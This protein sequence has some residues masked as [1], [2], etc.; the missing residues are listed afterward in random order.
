MLRTILFTFF[1]G[2]VL[3]TADYFSVGAYIH[4]EKWT[5]LAFFFVVSLLQHRLME[6]GFKENRERFVQFYLTTV[7][8]RLLM[9]LVFVG[10]FL[11]FKVTSPNSFVVTFFAFYLF[12]TCFEIYGLYRNL[13]RDLE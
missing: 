2:I 4:P 7:V 3:F 10:V 1:L 11:Y 9:C 5:I 12:Y 8:V 13:R 6:Q